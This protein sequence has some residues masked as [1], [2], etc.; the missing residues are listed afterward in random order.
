[1]LQIRFT[2]IPHLQS[3]I[4]S[5]VLD[6]YRMGLLTAGWHM[7]LVEHRDSADDRQSYASKSRC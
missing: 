4:K 2:R 7:F 6:S 5:E 1:M 3:S